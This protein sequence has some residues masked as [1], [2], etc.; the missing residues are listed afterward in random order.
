MI[1]IWGL[2]SAMM[3]TQALKVISCV[4]CHGSSPC[5]LCQI[6][7]WKDLARQYKEALDFILSISSEQ[8][9]LKEY[10]LV[11]LM[12]FDRSN[13]PMP[14]D[15]PASDSPDLG[16]WRFI[17]ITFDPSKFGISN[18]PEDEKNYIL[19]HILRVY[20]LNY[21]SH[22]LYGCFERHKT[23]GIHAHL[24]A[25]VI[26]NDIIV[27][28]KKAFTD[29]PKNKHAVDIG[30]AKFP[31]CIKYIEKESTDYFQL[32]DHLSKIKESIPIVIDE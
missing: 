6:K 10:Q 1:I 16:R 19:H 13:S 25:Y 11:E 17:T 21:C 9:K 3:L 31:Q 18:Q 8:L 4:I 15:L 29:N 20:N 30:F 27:E 24:V 23:G 14:F 5:S 22:P 7:Q 2:A 12:Q 32:N 26:N 28:L